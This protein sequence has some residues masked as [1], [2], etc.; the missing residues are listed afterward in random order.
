MPSDKRRKKKSTDRGKNRI[1]SINSKQTTMESEIKRNVSDI[2]RPIKRTGS[3]FER[4]YEI[5]KVIGRGAFGET[6]QAIQQRNREAVAIKIVDK[7]KD[8][9]RSVLEQE[10]LRK[11]SVHTNFPRLIASGSSKL[12]HM[13]INYFVMELLGENLSTLRKK[14]ADNRFKPETVLRIGIQGLHGL[15]TLHKNG[16]IHRDVKPPNMCIG[17]SGAKVRIVHLIDFGLARIKKLDKDDYKRRAF[18]AFKGTVRYVSTNVHERRAQHPIDDLLSLYYS[19]CELA[20]GKLPWR[21]FSDQDQVYQSKRRHKGDLTKHMPQS[22][23]NL[24]KMIDGE[25][26]IDSPDYENMKDLLKKLLPKG[27]VEA[28]TPYEWEEVDE[29]KDTTAAT[30]KVNSNKKAENLKKGETKQVL[31]LPD[32]S[33]ALKP[34]GSTKNQSPYQKIRAEIEKRTQQTKTPEPVAQTSKDEYVQKTFTPLTKPKSTTTVAATQ[35]PSQNTQTISSPITTPNIVDEKTLAA[36]PSSSIQSLYFP[37]SFQGK[38]ST[39]LIG[40]RKSPAVNYIAKLIEPTMI[41]YLLHLHVRKVAAMSNNAKEFLHTWLSKKKTGQTPNYNISSICRNGVQRFKCELRVTGHSYVGLG[42]SQSKKDAATNAAM[43]FCNYMVRQELIQ[44]NELPSFSAS[45]LEATSAPIMPG[46]SC[47]APPIQ[48]RSEMG[49]GDNISSNGTQSNFTVNR[50]EH[51]KYVQQKVEEVAKSESVDFR[52]ELHGGWTMD[53]SKQAI[54]EFLSKL[55]LPA[56]TYNPRKMEGGN[57][58]TF[59]C[60]VHVRLP[61]FNKTVTGRGQGSTKKVCE[62]QCAVNLVRQLFHMKLIKEYSGVRVKRTATNLEPINIPEDRALFERVLHYVNRRGLQPVVPDQSATSELPQNLLIDVK[63]TAFPDSEAFPGG[64]ISWAPAQQNWNPW[65]ACN[66]DTPPL[67]FQ[68]L[69]DISNGLA[70]EEQNKHL[71]PDVQQKRYEL[72]VH[73]YRQQLLQTIEHNQVTLIKGETG[74]GKSTQVAQYLLEHY[75]QQGRGAEFA[76]FVSQPRRISAISLA[77]RVAVERGEDL[78]YSVGYS[79]RFDGISPRPYG[80]LMFCT[81]GVLLRKMESGLRG[82]SHVFIDEIHERDI[83]TD[84]ILIVLREM[85]REYKDLRIILMSATIDT[86][87]FQSYFGGCPIVEMEGRTF[88]VQQFFIEDILRNLQFMPEKRSKF[89]DDEMEIE[90]TDES[91]TKARNLLMD[92][93]PD[94]SP[95]VREAM[96]NLNE[97]E[98]PF[99]VIE[100]ILKD[101]D[102]RGV[103]GSILI[104]LPGWNEIQALMQHLMKNSTF[105]NTNAY[106]ILPLHS[107]LSSMEQRKVFGHYGSKRK[108]II[109]T[110]IAETSVTID[111]VVFVIDSCKVREKMYTSHNNMVHFATVWASKTNLAQ[112]RGR[113]GRV[114][115]GFAFSLCSKARYQALEEHRM[116]EL[117][118]TPLHEI[119]LTIKLL[120]LG[121]I[122]DFLAKAIEPP[123]VDTVIEAEVILRELSALDRKSELTDL[124]RIIARLPIEPVLG[125]TIVLGCAMG[126]GAALCDV[127]AASSFSAPWVFAIKEHSR[128]NHRQKSLAGRY[129]SDHVCMIGLHQAYREAVNDGGVQGEQNFCDRY[130]VSP[131]ILKMCSGA[132]Q[133]MVD[134]LINQCGYPEDVMYDQH[135]DANSD[136]LNLDLVLSLLVQ[137]L[138]ILLNKLTALLSKG[139]V[140]SP[141]KGEEVQPPSPLL[142]FTEKVRT[143]VIACKEISAVSGIQLLLFGTRKVECIGSDIV[144][145][146]EM[147]VLRMN[148][149]DAAAI[150][151]LRP[152]IEA[153]LI[154]SCQNTSSVQTLSEEDAE[155][156]SLVRELC[157]GKFMATIEPA[158]DHILSDQ[159]SEHVS[160]PS[161]RGSFR[162]RPRGGFSG[163][164]GDGWNNRGDRGGFNR[165]GF[166]GGYNGNSN[167]GGPMFQ[168]GRGGGGGGRGFRPYDQRGRGGGG[169]RGGPMRGRGG[170]GAGF[171]D[172]VAQIVRG[173]YEDFFVSTRPPEEVEQCE[174]SIGNETTL[175]G[176]T[177]TTTPVT[178]V[179][180]CDWNK[181]DGIEA[182]NGKFY[183]GS[184]P[185]APGTLAGNREQIAIFCNKEVRTATLT[186]KSC[187][188]YSGNGECSHKTSST[189]STGRYCVKVKGNAGSNQIDVRGCAQISPYPKTGSYC[190][191]IK[192][193]IGNNANFGLE[194]TKQEFDGR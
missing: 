89:N 90:E 34:H 117:L 180:F 131:A 104:F 158:K 182:C 178:S 2:K 48:S 38:R 168:R 177:S 132:K 116:A 65:R 36:L 68:S 69:A 93:P 106:V 192:S 155:L 22:F 103:D 194:P 92:L 107:Q 129:W 144:R 122:G 23:L 120:N 25:D 173:C 78:G 85:S 100:A 61:Q 29:P 86:K 40:S 42:N 51:E 5:V 47:F 87:M 126:V 71:D 186:C 190:T 108:I 166:R 6:Y 121:S 187:S 17:W 105:G 112:R 109:S 125:R 191:R 162:G 179:R 149:A 26:F 84:F 50:S 127:A 74:C 67:A 174:F 160:A 41:L 59:V 20:E 63:L 101:I 21:D 95:M 75:I 115:E 165:G 99:D 167:S 136:D 137:A 37:Q 66:I 154:H 1:A 18:A 13:S 30:Q 124:G 183:T 148:V 24:Y 14:R 7:G 31:R 76:A 8:G 141:W 163:G 164:G 60:E 44:Q 153:L 146:D 49:Y 193:Q 39:R 88:P 169:F 28:N 64:S 77:E 151:A 185:N 16:Y 4:K 188:R 72:P 184:T 97:R 175:I 11:L 62:A 142:I 128:L 58:G 110:N 140:I 123:P 181:Q 33:Q 52:A 73:K 145:L 81:V 27:F 57:A 170:G 138:F 134:I 80:A 96:R 35:L 32:E 147:I 94:T 56:V 91:D 171:D 55:K 10:I 9:K 83:N 133:Q 118:R 70:E 15:E 43:D 130:S 119:A 176:I 172:G 161:T 114:R 143:K 189:C 113:A 98:I 53:N 157:A 19:L 159:V 156:V 152:C 54:N 12:S 139:S 45:S 135:I 150:V 3:L 46:G 102:L 79:V 82:I 111:D